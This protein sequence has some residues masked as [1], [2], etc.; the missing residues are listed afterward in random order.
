MTLPNA[1]RHGT[2]F[3]LAGFSGSGKTTLAEKLIRELTERGFSL[4]SI[5]H[6][7]HAFDPDT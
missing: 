6:A 3:G 1:A 7:H 5:K 4:A 2:V